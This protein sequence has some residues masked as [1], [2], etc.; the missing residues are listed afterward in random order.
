[1]A[2][3]SLQ[4]D[5]ARL[6]KENRFGLSALQE[7][8]RRLRIRFAGI[9]PRVDRVLDDDAFNDNL[10]ALLGEARLYIGKGIIL[11]PGKGRG[12]WAAMLGMQ[13]RG[14]ERCSAAM[15]IRRIPP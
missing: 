8:G 15:Q 14:F 5:A 9:G 1:M 11:D 2:A 10:T 6:A 12:I 13:I 3:L 4:L 7:I